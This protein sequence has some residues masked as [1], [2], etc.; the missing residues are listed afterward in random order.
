V[1]LPYYQVEQK[2][3]NYRKTKMPD[4]PSTIEDLVEKL[5]NNELLRRA[6]QFEMADGT[7]EDMFHGLVG[8][9]PHRA[10]IF[11]HPRM[12]REMLPQQ[13]SLYVDATFYV[14][15]RKPTFRQLL[16]MQTRHLDMVRIN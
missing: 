15:P 5:D 12:I 14:C 2:L 10:L 16:C 1:T 3:R 11:I 7:T 8:E 9:A 13:D 4:E 6:F